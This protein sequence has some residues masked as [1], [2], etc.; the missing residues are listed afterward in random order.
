MNNEKML[1]ALVI[2]ARLHI[3]G[4]DDRADGNG[5]WMKTWRT[6]TNT[7]I[8]THHSRASGLW[9][10][11]QRRSQ[12]GGMFQR[13]NPAYT[14][15]SNLFESFQDFAQWCQDQ[16]G[17]GCKD[18]LG[19]TWE[20]D[21]DIL[22]KGNKTYSKDTC[23]FVTR[24]INSMFTS[25]RSARGETPIGVSFIENRGK[26]RS[27]CNSEGRFLHLG[28]FDDALLANRA[29]QVEKVRVIRS[30]ASKYLDSQGA[31]PSV[32][33]AIIGRA[34]LISEDYE[35]NRITVEV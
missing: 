3:H 11:V 28:H 30:A 24:R 9:S 2:Q 15:A 7:E 23:C 32:Y 5:E 20:I 26:Y 18:A 14:G 21:K 17:Y 10:K 16:P 25:C 8:I 27:Y 12:V 1:S 34:L 33:L 13:S 19:N 35:N 31:A 22:V 29:W 4:C 6:R